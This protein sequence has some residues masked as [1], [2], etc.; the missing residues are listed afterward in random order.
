MIGATT[1][2]QPIVVRTSLNIRIVIQKSS[3]IRISVEVEY[4]GGKKVKLMPSGGGANVAQQPPHLFFGIVLQNRHSPQHLMVWN[5]SEL[6]WAIL[7]Q[8]SNQ[9]CLLTSIF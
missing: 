3:M 9:P 1:A 7:F 6:E 4:E 8:P 2:L 5:A